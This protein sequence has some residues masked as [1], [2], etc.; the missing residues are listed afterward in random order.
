MTSSTAFPARFWPL[1]LSAPVAALVLTAVHDSSL[2]LETLSTASAMSADAISAPKE[3]YG[4]LPLRFDE[5]T[6]QSDARVKYLAHG[7]D[8]SLFVTAEGITWNLRGETQNSVVRM[9]FAGAQA[10]P[11]I[12]GEHQLEGRSRY[13]LGRDTSKWVTGARSFGAVRFESLYAGIDAKLYGNERR[14]EYDFIVAPG[15]DP[16]QIRLRFEGVDG[17]ALTAS[18]DLIVRTAAGV[19]TQ[20]AP[21]AYQPESADATA[22]TAVTARFE[23]IGADEVAFRLGEYDE[24]RPLVID[25]VYEYSTYLG[26]SL[27]EGFSGFAAPDP[28]E[29]VFVNGA[30]E[31]YVAGVTNSTD[32]PQTTGSVQPASGGDLDFYIAKLNA[33][34]NAIQ[35]ATYLGGAGDELGIGGL[36]V[37]AAGNIYLAG[38]SQSADFPTTAGA[39]QP[40]HT[41]A[42]SSDG[43]VVIVKLNATGSAL[44]YSTYIGSSTGDRIYGFAVDSGGDAYIA[45][46]SPSNPTVPW[47]V[48]AGSVNTGD[49]FVARLNSTGTSLV[50]ATRFGDTFSNVRIRAMAIDASSNVYVAGRASA[51]ALVTSA[52]AYD[53]TQGG[54]FDAFV[55]KFS[56]AGSLLYASYLGG[57]QT[58]EGRAIALDAAGNIYV[59]GSTVQAGG[60]ND[61]PTTAGAFQTTPATNFTGFVTKLNPAGS[62]L[63]WSTYFAQPPIS[64]SN[65][66]ALDSAGRVYVGVDGSIPGPM[67]KGGPP[68]TCI[69]ATGSDAITRLSADGSTLDYGMRIGGATTFS[70]SSDVSAN[71]LFDVAV[72]SGNNVYVVGTTNSQQFPTYNGFQTAN[73]GLNPSSDAYIAKI[74][75]GTADAPPTVQFAQATYSAA[76]GG[77]ATITL[78]RAGRAAGVVRVQVA[79]SNGTA[80]AGADYTATTTNVS[81]L[82]GDLTPKTFTVPIADDGAGD[83]GETIN[84][85][86][87]KNWCLGDPGAQ[88]TAVL[89]T[90]EAGAPPASAGTLQLSAA[91]YS[92]N[93]SGPSA[94]IAVTRTGGSAG[95]VSARLVTSDGMAT[96][97]TDY[98]AADTIVTFVDGDVAQKLVPV[99]VIQDTADEPDET[100]NITLSAATGG[101]TLGTQTTAVLTVADD[102]V[103]PT[104]PPV[105]PPVTP[106]A[107]GGGGGGAMD[108]I[109]LLVLLAIGGSVAWVRSVRARRADL[110]RQSSAHR[111]GRS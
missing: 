108:W 70:S 88:A 17:L 77:D 86:L 39:F 16:S 103:T 91:T 96:A 75:D 13:F 95:A 9:R 82:D 12:R 55:A 111:Y 68:E 23:L 90:T 27:S 74:G 53:S 37:D 32:F 50:Y 107:S 80:A 5:N 8:H 41:P 47:P 31:A 104:T 54:S 79:T 89:T 28:F 73:G 83:N 36:H 85:T 66:I 57:S 60:P 98:T 34:G 21:V 110:L 11:R 71:I 100:V 63:V 29:A 19:L 18:G 1:L 105:T 4:H 2:T 72:D 61:F 38:M 49:Q 20:H 22:R 97:G 6:G 94:S 14:V 56:A 25:P 7:R 78:N 48:T 45:G 52:G 101:A 99:N 102:D 24:R 30:G 43:D 40:A 106:P 69:A 3:K 81:W 64:S 26:G 15:A 93:E 84:L 62:A 51:N 59:A 67:R 33:S 10:E 65:A 42:G 35:F 46:S 87:T 92:V 44:V 58:D 76:E 109:A